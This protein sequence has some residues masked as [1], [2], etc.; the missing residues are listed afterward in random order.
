MTAVDAQHAWII[1]DD[2]ANGGGVYATIDGGTNWSNQPSAFGSSGEPR[3]VKSFDTL[4][5]LAVG[6]PN[7]GYWEIYT[8]SNGG[9]T[10][11]RVPSGNIPAPLSGET[12]YIA[13]APSSYGN[14][15]WFPT[16]EQSLYRTTDRGLTWTVNRTA[17]PG[18]I[19]FGCAFKD[20]LNGLLAGDPPLIRRTTDG[21]VTFTDAGAAP[22]GMTPGFLTYVPGTTGS[23]MMTQFDLFGWS[24]GSAYTRDDGATWTLIDTKNHGRSVF[25]D[26]SHGWSGGGNDSLFA[27]DE[28]GYGAFVL[29][30]NEHPTYLPTGFT[31]EQNYPN[32]FN[33]TTVI[34]FQLPVGENVKIAVYNLLG[35]QVAVLADRD[36]AAGSHT[37]TFNGSGL[38]TGSYFYR[39]E[40]GHFTATKK[41][42]LIK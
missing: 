14:S 27:W 41:M 8:T 22:A 25:L 9:G 36:Y 6:N 30:V 38:T 29:P 19:G 13:G 7:G 31:L 32:P 15:F 35:Q 16:S 40:S 10:W 42:I 3:F 12:A 24:P 34:S 2:A 28:T 23:Y 21:G 18:T 20:S 1:V 33:P 17:F 26:P 37:V 4:N 39:I 5:G 11:T